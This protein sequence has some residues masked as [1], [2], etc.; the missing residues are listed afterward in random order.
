MTSLRSATERDNRVTSFRDYQ[1]VGDQWITIVDNP[2]YPDYL[3]AARVV[4]EPVL[5]RFGELVDEADDSADLLRRIGRER[6][7]L[8]GQLHRVFKNYVSPDTSVEMLKGVGRLERTIASFGDRFRPL[9]EVS[10]RFHSRPE[11]DEAL[12]AVLAV[13]ADRGRKVTP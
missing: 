7:Q 9:N 4:Y 8:R 13:Q 6:K 1:S 5:S 3:D 2:F 10:V 12:S 11:L